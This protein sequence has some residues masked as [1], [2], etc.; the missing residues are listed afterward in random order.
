M[1]VLPRLYPERKV[2]FV[3]CNESSPLPIFALLSPLAL[4]AL[5]PP[6]LLFTWIYIVHVGVIIQDES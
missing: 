1:R 5:S 3:R 2:H 4:H 6:I